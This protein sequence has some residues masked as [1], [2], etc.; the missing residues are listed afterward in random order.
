MAL[1]TSLAGRLM[2]VVESSVNNRSNRSCSSRDVFR[3][4]ESSITLIVWGQS[5]ARQEGSSNTI[6]RLLRRNAFQDACP[7]KNE[8]RQCKGNFLVPQCTTKV[9]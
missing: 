2:N 5:C 1:S 4:W 3:C 8:S 9:Q 6:R 7:E